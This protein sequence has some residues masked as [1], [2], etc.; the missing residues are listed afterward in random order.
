MHAANARTV[1]LRGVPYL[2]ATLKPLDQV[3]LEAGARDPGQRTFD[4][5]QEC[6]GMCGV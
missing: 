4:F 2:H 6:E 3:D 5:N 1:N